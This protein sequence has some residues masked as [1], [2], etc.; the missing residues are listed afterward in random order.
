MLGP[1]RSSPGCESQNIYCSGISHI[2]PAILYSHFTVVAEV[3]P[4]LLHLCSA[5]I[6][7]RIEATYTPDA[8][9]V[10]FGVGHG[11]IVE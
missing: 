10:W 5:Y 6:H 1:D 4:F 8:T 7:Y 3:K 9:K 11:V 2:T